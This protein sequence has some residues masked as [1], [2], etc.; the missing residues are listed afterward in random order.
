MT[1][2]S[3]SPYLVTA[4]VLSAALALLVRMIRSWTRGET[5]CSRCQSQGG[6]VIQAGPG[7]RGTAA[8]S[9]A[10]N[11]YPLSACASCQSCPSASGCSAAGRDQSAVSDSHQ[12]DR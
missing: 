6:D 1:F 4:A 12:V 8:D 2:L 10:V 7:T 11:R 5:S 3:L 9:R